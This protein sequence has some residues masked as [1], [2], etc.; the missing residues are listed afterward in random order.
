MAR[1]CTYTVYRYFRI[2]GPRRTLGVACGV[3]RI[4]RNP[5]LIHQRP[6]VFRELTIKMY[7][8]M[9]T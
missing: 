3:N 8:S 4:D 7:A 1:A 2:H 9:E 5:I 6:A